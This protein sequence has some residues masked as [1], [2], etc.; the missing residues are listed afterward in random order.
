M[1]YR[2][3]QYD[4]S[5]KVMLLKLTADSIEPQKARIRDEMLEVL[6]AENIPKHTESGRVGGHGEQVGVHR[7]PKSRNMPRARNQCHRHPKSSKSCN[8]WRNIGPHPLGLDRRNVFV[9]EI[10]RTECE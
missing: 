7:P 2:C 9:S 1:H 4:G 6:V 3:Y 10:D 5:K 8:R